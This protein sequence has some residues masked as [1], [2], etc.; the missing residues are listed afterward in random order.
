MSVNYSTERAY[1]ASLTPP[2]AKASGRGRFSKDAKAALENA[3]KN[4]VTFDT[5]KGND[6]LGNHLP[7]AAKAAAGTSQSLSDIRT[8]AKANGYDIGVRGRIPSDV[9]NAYNGDPVKSDPDPW[10]AKP[11]PHQP[12]LRQLDCLYGLTEEGYRVGFS[13]CRRCM[14]HLSRCSCKQGPMPPS[15]VVKMLDQTTV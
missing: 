12:R 8:W 14:C 11:A 7:A 9:L 5:D 6:S 10:L 1:L 15:I 4:G 13:T 2:L 3:R